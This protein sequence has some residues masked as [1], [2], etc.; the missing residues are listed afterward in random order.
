MKVQVQKGESVLQ[1]IEA[2]R[3]QVATR[4][5]ELFRTRGGQLGRALD[6]WLTAERETVWTPAAE[7]SERERAFCLELATPG[8]DGKD[9]D[10]RVTAED[11]VV[12]APV[13]HQPASPGTTV[14]LC[15]FERGCLFRSVH[16]PKPVNPAGAKA[17]YQNG[18]LR[19]TLPLAK[20]REQR[21]VVGVEGSRPER[22]DA[23]C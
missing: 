4:A 17:D 14:H 16:L 13:H 7:L 9:L 11:V 22:V 6:D 1:E 10:V 23:E 19:L 18:L 5:H 21:V 2:L 20:P 3:Q 8:V 12:T 15:E